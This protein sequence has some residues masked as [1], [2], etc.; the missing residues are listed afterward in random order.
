MMIQSLVV[1]LSLAVLSAGKLLMV[2]EL[3]RH[4]ARYPI[5]ASLDNYS[6]YAVD[7]KI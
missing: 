2:Q 5:Y 7:G 6:T 1:L 3:F 4:G